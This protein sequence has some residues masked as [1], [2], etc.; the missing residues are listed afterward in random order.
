[1]HLNSQSQIKSTCV[2]V[3]NP[4]V[5]C[6]SDPNP[7]GGIEIQLSRYLELTSIVYLFITL[8]PITKKGCL[9]I[10]IFQFKVPLL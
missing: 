9:G 3:I 6:M 4:K 1:M 7:K 8:T 2:N 5:R 10:L